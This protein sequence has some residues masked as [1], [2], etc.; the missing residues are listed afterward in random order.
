MT[1]NPEFL[2]LFNDSLLNLSNLTDL[3]EDSLKERETFSNNLKNKLSQINDRLKSFSEEINELKNLVNSLTAKVKTN[4]GLIAQLQKGTNARL[5]DLTEANQNTTQVVDITS[6]QINELSDKMKQ[7][8]NELNNK[9][10]E[11][12]QLKE[13]GDNNNKVLI[14]EKE[15][16]VKNLK[17][18]IEYYKEQGD[19]Y[20]TQLMNTNDLLSG[21]ILAA[22]KIINNATA[23]MKQL[24]DSAPN[25]QTREE[26]N[27]ILAS[28][29]T[30]IKSMEDINNEIVKS[31]NNDNFDT[32]IKTNPD[33]LFSLG[34]KMTRKRRKRRKNKKQKGGFTYKIK[35]KRKS[36]IS[37]TNTPKRSSKSRSSRMTR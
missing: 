8:E 3:V 17:E 27:T 25:A 29:E 19:N 1:Q 7:L 20:Y 2:T 12:E 21:K 31:F 14:I 10:N 34:G 33:N 28:I 4:E 18:Q 35:S 11:I 23:A 9:N 30:H 15:G 16:E 32:T 13:K 5:A 6:K 36:I 22:T 26:I 37:K 24:L